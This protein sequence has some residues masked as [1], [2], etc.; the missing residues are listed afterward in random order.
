ML[1]SKRLISPGLSMPFGMESKGEGRWF[2]SQQRQ[3]D[4]RFT[5]SLWLL[6]G[7]FMR[8]GVVWLC[9]PRHSYHSG[10][11]RSAGWK[12]AQA[13]CGARDRATISAGLAIPGDSCRDDS[14]RNASRAQNGS[15]AGE[16]YRRADRTCDGRSSPAPSPAGAS[17]FHGRVFREASIRAGLRCRYSRS[18]RDHP[19]L[20]LP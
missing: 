18:R 16:K 10:T 1:F 2:R 20:V 5:K 4:T 9:E 15:S 13:V 12:R 8:A 3:E 11:P 6:Y 14:R 7:F 19:N 17:T